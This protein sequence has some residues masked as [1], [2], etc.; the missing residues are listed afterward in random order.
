[1]D[2]TRTP[3]GL[4]T[5]RQLEVLELVAKGLTNAEI[6]QVLGIAP[7]TAKNHVA[8][9]LEALD[10]SNR[11]EAV[12]I[13]RELAAHDQDAEASHAVPGFGQRPTLALLPLD[14]L[15]PPED[16]YIA[17]G[18][19]EDLTTALAAW[20][21]FPVI[22]RNSTFAYKGPG[23]DVREVSRE[24]GARY[25]V[26]GSA[27]RS[28]DRLRV[29]V[30]LI[31][32]ESGEHHWAQRYD[33]TIGDLFAVQDEIVADIV[34]ALEPALAQIERMRAM[35]QPAQDLDAWAWLQRGLHR[36]WRQQ[37]GDPIA[38]EAL[39]RRATLAAPDAAAAWAALS[40]CECVWAT[41]G[42]CDD[43]LRWL[44]KGE[45][46]ARRAI[47]LDPMDFAGYLGLGASLGLRGKL[48][49]AASELERATELNPSC[50]QAWF[51]LGALAL[52][53]GQQEQAILH[54]EKAIRLSPR[55]PMLHH[56][57]GV[58]AGALLWLQD[59]GSAL[60]AAQASVA[61]EPSAAFSFRP[62]LAACLGHLGRHEEA[63][64][65]RDEILA[66]SPG[67][68]L[69]PSRALAHGEL[70][71]RVAEGFRCFGWDPE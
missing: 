26:E 7:G 29:H 21:W 27:R 10:V 56:F 57:H 71:D 6:A 8:A 46:S 34:S 32:G 3:G 19:V 65:V 1:M 37:V 38:A 44:A 50:A 12:G 51:G 23:V 70:V 61:V 55:D 20:R 14:N 9:V 54:C 28:G 48:T 68:D 25:V 60:L 24:L 4:L 63:R 52:Q 16:D 15:G 47:E 36:L 42:E 49:E 45:T 67:F 43:P 5:P 13:L 69:G 11:T 17:D 66:L 18:L 31:D 62:L 33:R 30:Q 59:Y 53:P 35:R 41:W 39:L 2:E 64:A 22:A 40:Y 58:R